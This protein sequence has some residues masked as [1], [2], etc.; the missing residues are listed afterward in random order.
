MAD[1]VDMLFFLHIILVVVFSFV[2][3]Y[4]LMSEVKFYDIRWV[5]L[6]LIG[7]ILNYGF[8]LV[9]LILDRSIL[10]AT[11]FRVS[12]FFLV[13]NFLFFFVEL[14]FYVRDVAVDNIVKPRNSMELAKN[15]RV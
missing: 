10:F 4:N 12:S 14:F 7:F 8:G 13:L 6:L 5:W 9:L 1:I 2:K 15:G 3:I 11:L